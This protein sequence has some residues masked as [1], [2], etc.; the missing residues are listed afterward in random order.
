MDE[1]TAMEKG[2][3]CPQALIVVDRV[4]V[5]PDMAPDIAPVKVPHSVLAIVS[6]AVADDPDMI[7]STVMAPRAPG[8]VDEDQVPD[9]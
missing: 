2:K 4:S 1:G 8:Y 6:D 9:Q 7:K 5:E 3:D